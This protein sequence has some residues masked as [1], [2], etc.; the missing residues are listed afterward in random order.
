MIL[1]GMWILAPLLLW[2]AYRL[3]CWI[4]EPNR[5]NDR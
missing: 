3:A 5:R 4:G 1:N 2:G